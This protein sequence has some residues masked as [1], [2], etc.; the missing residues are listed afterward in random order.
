MSVSTV[1]TQR[2]Y[3]ALT[4]TQREPIPAVCAFAKKHLNDVKRRSGETYA[5]HGLEVALA[6]CE[7]VKDPSLLKV[8]LL[9]DLPLHP[10]GAE[11]LKSAPVTRKEKDLI[12]QMH[13]LRRLHIDSK[14]ED[15]DTVISAFMEDSK[16]LPL[17]MAHRLNDVR[18]LSRFTPQLQSNIA[19]ETLHMYT[20]I[21]GRLGLNSWRVEMEN[22][23][24]QKLHPVIT[25]KLKTQFANASRL[26]TACLDQTKTFLHTMLQKHGI[27]CR[28]EYR[29]KSL[30]STYRKMVLKH[31][32]FEELTDRIALRV[33]VKKDMDCYKALAVVHAHMHPIPGKLKDYIGAPKENG[34]KSIHTVVYPLPGVTEQPI[35]VQISTE[36]MHQM[37]SMECCRMGNIRVPY[38]PWGHVLLASTYLET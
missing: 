10:D 35:E 5:Q 32:S 3:R 2:L 30:Y 28:F 16:L 22:I 12:Q 14:T 20:A 6:L 15:L 38:I 9:H 24:F 21:A 8:A 17:R 31:R 27:A 7:L 36:E 26:D 33:I 4:K 19:R 23:C 25:Q 11:L 29:I 37:L 1:T 18:H 34:Y 13:V